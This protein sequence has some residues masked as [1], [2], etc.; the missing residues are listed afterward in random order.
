MVLISTVAEAESLRLRAG[1]SGK[2]EKNS[3]EFGNILKNSAKNMAMDAIFE[4]AGKTF[5]LSPDLLRAVAKTESDFNPNAVSKAGA[6]GV[7]QLMPGTAKSLGV[8]DPYDPWQNIM[9]GAK[10]LKENLD[11]FK[12]VKLAL[13][14]YNAG[15]GSV[16]KYGGIPP[17]EETQNYVK[18]VMGYMGETLTADRDVRSPYKGMAGNSM[19]G[20]SSFLAGSD[21]Y[22]GWGVNS[23]T[24]TPGV[25]ENLSF[26]QQG[27]EIV[28]DKESFNSLIQILRIQMMMNA[29]REIGVMEI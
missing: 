19:A 4:Q 15:P 13:A 22:R 16:Q 3:C 28:M 5:G 14:A 23:L 10:Y 6:M 18:K 27:D 25:F 17:Y 12:D 2:R 26:R 21:V 7:M 20:N 8:A 1:E 11:R 9:G 24:N 29:G